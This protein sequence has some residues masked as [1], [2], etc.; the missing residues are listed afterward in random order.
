MLLWKIY[1]WIFAIIN[2]LTLISFEYSLDQFIGFISLILGIGV[3]IAAFS[4][5]YKKPI[6]SKKILE[7]LFKLSIGLIGVFLLFEVLAFFQ[8]LFGVGINLP[9]SG[10]ISVFASFPAWPG[11]YA[12]YKLANH[13]ALKSKKKSKKKA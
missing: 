2:V 6:F 3:N 8:E 12:A 4:Y 11:I 5:A 1:V 13:K 9:T 10:F 7:W